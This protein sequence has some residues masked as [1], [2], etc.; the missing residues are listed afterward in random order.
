MAEPFQSPDQR[1]NSNLA[2]FWLGLSGVVLVIVLAALLARVTGGDNTW[3]YVV[4]AAFVASIVWGVLRERARAREIR[5]FAARHGL[6]YIGGAGPKSFA[7]HRTDSRLAHSIT[8]AVA[9]DGRTNEIVFFD[10][11]LG[12]GKPRFSRTVVGTCGPVRFG[13]AR[14]GLDLET[15][16]VDEWLIVFG[17]RRILTAEEIEALLSEL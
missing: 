8:A 11:T 16:R 4:G 17:S 5:E 9:G 13:P 12:H 15:E 3:S 6:T 2:R 7:L 14:H 10:C 1:L